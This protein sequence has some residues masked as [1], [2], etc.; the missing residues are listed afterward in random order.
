MGTKS[1]PFVTFIDEFSRFTWIF[2]LKDRSELLGVFQNFFKE[3]KNQFGCFIRILRSDNAK[4]YF[5]TS[6]NSFMS[7]N[8][9]IHQSSSPHTPQQNGIVE[10]KHHHIIETTCALL[11]NANVPMKF[12]GDVVLT[13]RYL[14]NRMSSSAIQNKVPHSILFP[15]EP[16]FRIDPRVFGS[17]CFVH[18][19]TLGLD[20]LCA[21]A[22]KCI[23]LGYSRVQKGYQCVIPQFLT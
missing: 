13:A 6:F 7:E 19:L 12:W 21:R 3:I 10:R 5:S 18:D 16:L 4:E 11:I 14:I 2:L 9:V 22:I 8:G 1:S 17:T 23:F 15:D 20:K